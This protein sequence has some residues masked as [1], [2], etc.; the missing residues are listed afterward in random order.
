MDE[1]EKTVPSNVCPFCT[2]RK[3][4]ST[5]GCLNRTVLRLVAWSM[6]FKRLFAKG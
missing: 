4:L 5:S 1:Y 3:T 2:E 6:G